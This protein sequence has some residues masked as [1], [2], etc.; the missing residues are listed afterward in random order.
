MELQNSYIFLKHPFKED[1]SHYIDENGNQVFVVGRNVY[2][3]IKKVFPSTSKVDDIDDF[4][5]KKFTSSIILNDVSYNV[6]FKLTEV[7]DISYLDVSV[8]GKTKSQIITCLEYIQE[9]I[10]RSGI[11]ENFVDIISYDAISEYYCNKIFSKLNTL[12]RNLRKL[13]FNIYVLNFGKDYYHATMADELQ[14]KIKKLINTGGNN[15]K[16]RQIKEDYKVNSK[17]AENIER[18]QE[19]FYSF[20]FKDIQTFLFEVNWT[21]VEEEAK[22]KFLS[23]HKDLSQLSDVELRNAFSSFTPKS[24]WERF[25][26]DKIQLTN[27]KYMIEQIRWYRNKVAHF[28]FFYKNDY[29]SCNK[30]ILKLNRAILKAINITEEKDFREKNAE[31]LKKALSGFSE[32]LNEILEPLKQT[33]Q[34][35][36]QSEGFKMISGV[37]QKLQQS[38]IV[39]Q[40]ETMTKSNSVFNHTQ[41]NFNFADKI[42]FPTVHIQSLLPPFIET[43]PNL[44]EPF[45]TDISYITNLQQQ[46]H[47]INNML[48]LNENIE[49]SDMPKK[50]YENNNDPND[51]ETTDNM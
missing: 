36:T 10:L 43:L 7:T 3:Y 8:E 48:Q 37:S 5:N 9:K 29:D 11:R 12:E 4:Y 41:N 44:M 40:L 47:L 17:Q 35:L 14:K 32:K 21:R 18:L 16:K 49:K 27:I 24:D 20:E 51:D 23:E 46:S 25:F 38:G 2:S 1:K 26:N 6:S 50:H 33:I 39:K 34:K 22:E 42:N 28:K 30:L 31:A 15:E 13:L 19:F 45:K